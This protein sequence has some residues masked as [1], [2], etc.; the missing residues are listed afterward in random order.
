MV[1]PLAVVVC[2]AIPALLGAAAWAGCAQLA[3]I[4]NTSD[5]GRPG[6]SVAV[7]R[8]SIGSKVVQA[9]LDPTGFTA[10]YFVASAGSTG[11]DRVMADPDPSH[12]GW[13]TKLRM[14]APVEFTLPDAP[15][16]VP[17][18]FAFP[19]PQLAVAHVV[20]EHPSPQPAPE[21]ATFAL[22]VT[23]DT[24]VAA[25]QTF[26]TYVVGAWLK[27]DLTGPEVPA[28][29][30]PSIALAALAF[31]AGSS[32]S[33]RAQIDQVTADDAFLTL[34]YVGADLTGVAEA[35]AF[36]QTAMATTVPAAT[37]VPVTHDQT[38][39]V[40]IMPGTMAA[41]YAMV[42]PA[43]TGL[44]IGWSV[45]AAPGYNLASNTGPGLHGGSLM[46][47]DVG[48]K[49]SYG[50]PFAA[51]GWH[52]IFTL[53]TSQSRV[54]PPNAAMGTPT[55]ALSAGMN[56]FLEPP[57]PAPDLPVAL[58][59]PAGLPQAIRFDGVV[60]DHDDVTFTARTAF[61]NVSFTVDA[62]M[63]AA[64]P[65][66]GPALYEL[67]VYELVTSATAAAIERQLVIAALST[68][69]AFQLPPELFQAGHRYSL[70]AVTTLGGYPTAAQGNFVNRQLP[71]AQSYLDGGVIMVTP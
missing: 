58:D 33:G 21:G 70:R 35:P 28:A 7:T 67:D 10:T 3:G 68:A 30:A 19:N 49:A 65:P 57:Q 42:R 14:P 20:L 26:Q 34:R 53:G 23:L 66:P 4:D 62:P 16:P 15:T 32:V 61:V 46:T 2:R 41:R 24:P 25:G 55:I 63:V 13:T 18:L 50:N 9:P 59:L 54:Y 51:R 44:Q 45:V 5:S 52:T 11:F 40:G 36:A 56:Q 38:V 12:G 69:P 64:G 47:M 6:D 22:D 31:P 1:R 8:M 39:N 37:M 29:G 17:R 27:H 60:L 48:V 43:V 71:L